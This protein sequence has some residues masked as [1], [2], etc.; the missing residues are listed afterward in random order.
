MKLNGP[1]AE[2]RGIAA[3]F[4]E[5]GE[6]VEAVK[7]GVLDRLGHHGTGELLKAHRKFRLERTAVAQQQ[8]LAQEIE[9]ALVDLGAIGFGRLDRGVDIALIVGIYCR[10]IG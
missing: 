1:N 3:D 7:G 10:V 9:E 8:E 6:A 4:I 2:A 5:R